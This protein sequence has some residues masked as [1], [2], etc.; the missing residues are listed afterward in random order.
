MKTTE[1]KDQLQN[2]KIGKGCKISLSANKIE[3]SYPIHKVLGLDSQLQ[4]DKA[5]LKLLY[6][7]CE[8]KTYSHMNRATINIWF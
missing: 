5:L 2:L 3:I 4:K 6:P 7:N 8:Q 1:I